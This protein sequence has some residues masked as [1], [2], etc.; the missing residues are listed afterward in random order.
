[1]DSSFE[2]TGMILSQIDAEGRLRPA[3]YGSI[4]MSERESRYSQPKLELFGLYRALRHWRLYIIGVQNLH[5]EV[6]AKYIKGM[7]NEPDLQPNAAINRWI[8]GIL[9]FD[10]KLIHVPATRFRGPDALSRRP[11]APDESAP[12]D[13][14]EWLD[15]IALYTTLI[16]GTQLDVDPNL[17]ISHNSSF[18]FLPAIFAT[19][20]AQEQN[21]RDIFQFLGTL[22]IPSE[23]DQQKR[24]RF[25][26]KASGY[27]REASQ[28]FERNGNRPPLLVIMDTAK[29]ISIL[30]QS[31][32]QLGHKG[33]HAI[34]NVLRLRFYWPCLR[35][36]I[37][38]H[39]KSCHQCQIRNTR[40]MEI[41]P[42]VSTPVHLFQKIY[43]DIM[44]MPV[45]NNGYKFII[46]AR[47]DLSGI[48]EARALT[49]ATSQA[50]ADF[51][52]EQIYCRYGA[53]DRV[54]TDNGSEFLGAFKILLKR[55][56]I[57]QVYIS[58]YNKHAN[59]EYMICASQTVLHSKM[60][61]MQGSE[62]YHIFRA[63]I[64]SCARTN[65]SMTQKI[66]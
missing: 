60:V 57:K 33:I 12:D 17:P 47:D 19:R 18:P 16:D 9:M 11:L 64:G 7:L 27:F 52:W 51:F 21:L 14:D 49:E 23:L 61:H 45:G 46:A 42:T 30:E 25:I 10:F 41:P 1:M 63:T 62:S 22:E 4:P 6:D 43:A 56:G 66:L 40:E 65:L 8:Q 15:N 37:Q 34:F 50:I 36:D 53:P 39:V 31:H 59:M 48:C 38:H 3:R 24:R 35:A 32:E 26:Q 28:L 20:T 2:A 58:P 13:D 29:R 44:Q 55:V 54:V 5:V